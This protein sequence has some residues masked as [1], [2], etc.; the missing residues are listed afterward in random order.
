MATHVKALRVWLRFAEGCCGRDIIH[1]CR[2]LP[3]N[4]IDAYRLGSDSV[5]DSDILFLCS[6]L[7]FLLFIFCFLPFSLF[8]SLYSS[9][10]ICHIIPEALCIGIARAA[11]G[12]L[13]GN[14]YLDLLCSFHHFLT[15]GT[16][17][18]AFVCKGLQKGGKA[19]SRSSQSSCGLHHPHPLPILV[20]SPPLLNLQSHPS[21]VL[22][23]SYPHR[24]LV[25]R[26]V[27][28][29]RP[30]LTI[31]IRLGLIFVWL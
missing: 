19:F 31:Q 5:H 21:P 26:H 12:H 25:H 3:G 8:F 27:Y 20:S 15:F 23:P 11:L 24:L 17:L 10:P 14:R 9:F 13:T 4:L 29:N 16:A 28:W 2:G 18:G 1:T 22:L 30:G 6:G 7:T